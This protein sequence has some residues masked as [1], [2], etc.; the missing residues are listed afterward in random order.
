MVLK[1]EG[2]GEFYSSFYFH[3]PCCFG[4][5]D[6]SSFNKIPAPFWGLKK[7][8]IDFFFALKIYNLT[9]YILG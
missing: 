8:L 1:L 9:Y 2:E 4:C 3:D 7:T 6:F 5:H